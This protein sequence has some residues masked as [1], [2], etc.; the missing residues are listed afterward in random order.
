VAVLCL[1]GC[2]KASSINGGC[3]G[4]DDCKGGTVCVAKA[5]TPVCDLDSECAS[6]CCVNG[7]C[8][9]DCEGA[10]P[11]ITTV[12]G[13]GTPDGQN[14]HAAHHVADRLM[15]SGTNLGDATVTLSGDNLPDQTLEL[16]DASQDM[17]VAQLPEGLVAGAYTLTVAN[18][19]GS[20]N[21]NATLL[22]GEPGQPGADGDQGPPGDNGAP[23]PKGDAGAP[24]SSGGGDTVLRVS[25]RDTVPG[26]RSITLDGVEQVNTNVAGLF[27]VVLDP[28]DLSLISRANYDTSSATSLETDIGALTAGDIV[29]IASTGD[30]AAMFSGTLGE[31]LQNVGGSL[32][33]ATPQVTTTS[34]YALIGVVV[35]GSYG[36]DGVEVVSDST[37]GPLTLSGRWR[38]GELVGGTTIYYPGWTN[39][40]Y[41]HQGTIMN[42]AGIVMQRENGPAYLI[43]TGEPELITQLDAGAGPEMA[44]QL[45]YDAGVQQFELR[46]EGGLRF[47]NGTSSD[48]SGT[49]GHRITVYGTPGSVSSYAIGIESSNLWFNSNKGFKWYTQGAEQMRIDQTSGD[50]QVANA[51]N[52][53]GALDVGENIGVAGDAYVTGTVE[54]DTVILTNVGSQIMSAGAASGRT[55]SSSSC[56]ST[57]VGRLRVVK[58][59]STATPTDAL[60]YCG[61]RSDTNEY[62]WRCI[63]V[64]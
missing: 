24:G 57:T 61:N 25:A 29:L 42:G 10:A 54:A 60:C 53:A 1:V 37:S 4:N 56:S 17:L 14:D 38:D 9:T 50:L 31:T 51:A 64:M 23:G 27:M 43:K 15:L 36:S 12:D 48:P 21:V 16:C 28:T 6:G 58:D 30:I 20:C 34:A 62:L 59:T 11:E 2:T 33:A 44:T 35:P 55:Y 7:A 18:A 45:Y 22:Q 32:I 46:I 41:A 52:I 5:C 39:P 47:A 8:S 13:L 49:T 40:A 3:A 63:K 26:E 19:A